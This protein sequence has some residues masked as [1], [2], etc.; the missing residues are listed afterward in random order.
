MAILP[1]LLAVFVTGRVVYSILTGKPLKGLLLS[2][3]IAAAVI[4]GARHAYSYAQAW[5]AGTVGPTGTAVSAFDVLATT[6]MV[7]GII[8]LVRFIVKGFAK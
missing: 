4:S 2:A 3:V 7:V 6:T 8:F 5:Q 1:T